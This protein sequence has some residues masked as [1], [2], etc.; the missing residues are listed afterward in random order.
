MEDSYLGICVCNKVC[1]RVNSK[2]DSDDY[3]QVEGDLAIY[4]PG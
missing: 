1:I 3:L 2:L 4:M